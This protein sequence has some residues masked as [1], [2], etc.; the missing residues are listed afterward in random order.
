M[1]KN[2]KSILKFIFLLLLIITCDSGGNLRLINR[3]GVETKKIIFED[4]SIEISMHTLS[5]IFLFEIPL[6]FS[7]NYDLDVHIDSLKIF[8]DRAQKKTK[9]ESCKKRSQLKSSNN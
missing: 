6:I 3:D 5:N 8:F 4:F 7:T 1:I 9:G 2:S